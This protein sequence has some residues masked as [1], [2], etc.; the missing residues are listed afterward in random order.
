LLETW[1]DAQLLSGA[2]QD[3][4]DIVSKI[5]VTI[6]ETTQKETVKARA[7]NLGDKKLHIIEEQQISLSDFGIQV[8]SFMCGL[9]RVKD[10][11]VFNFDLVVDVI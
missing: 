5:D 2:S 4:F 3:W 6:K 10:Q 11:I 8:P 9:V 1:Q 7:Q